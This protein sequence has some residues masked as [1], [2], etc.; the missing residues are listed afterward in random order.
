M[1]NAMT[2]G[3]G[4]A[5]PSA[6]R[7]GIHDRHLSATARL[8]GA[9][10]LVL[11]VC[12]G[13]ARGATFHVSPTGTDADN[14][15]AA[16]PW[17]TIQRCANQAQPGDTCRVH[18]GVYR[19]TVTPPRSGTAAA[20]IRFE[21]APGE[22]V[23]VSGADAF[24]GNWQPHSGS[25]WVTSTVARFVQLFSGGRMLNEARWPN[26]DPADLV[27][28]PFSR[29]GPGTDAS[30]LVAAAV[31]PGDW[32]GAMV[33]VLPG[34]GW[35]SE[36]RQVTTYDV[37]TRRMTFDNSF[38]SDPNLAPKQGD[39]YYL[40]GSLLALDS[41][42]EWFLDGPGSKLYL[43]PPGEIDPGTLALEI[44]QRSW[45]FDVT[46]LAY[47]E[48]A[49]F[50]IVASSIRIENSNFC[51][52]DGV[53]MEYVAHVRDHLGEYDT[54][55]GDAPRVIGNGNV[56]K[57]TVIA[58]S[59][60]M[61]LGIQGN[62][63]VIV[64]NVIHDIAY[65]G[66]M[67]GGIELYPWTSN[68]ARNMIAYNS[69]SRAGSRGIGLSGTKS[70]RILFNA[71]SDFT[72]LTND[73][74]GISAPATTLDADNTE[75]AY[76]EVASGI[77]VY[78]GGIYLDDGATNFVVHHNYVHDVA[79]WGI[80]FKAKNAVFNNTVLA[81]GQSPIYMNVSMPGNA[82]DASLS[83]AL[84]LN[85]LLD[86][87]T[88]LV[89]QLQ[90]PSVGDY[91]WFQSSVR[92]TDQWRRVI[93][94]FSTLSQPG[95]A[96]PVAFDLKAATTLVWQPVT[97]GDFDVQ[98]DNVTMEGASP[99]T[100]VD[101]ESGEL[102]TSLGTRLWT[103][104]GGG[105]TSTLSTSHPG[106]SCSRH[107]GSLKGTNAIQG[108]VNLGLPLSTVANG[109]YDLSG[110]SALSFDVRGRTRAWLASTSG[111]TPI[112][113]LNYACPVD[114]STAPTTT[115]AIDKAQ[116]VPPY[117][118]TFV[119]T[120]PDIGA[121]EAGSPRWAAGAQFSGGGGTC[122]PPADVQLNL[123]VS[124]A[125]PVAPSGNWALQSPT[126]WDDVCSFQFNVT[127]TGSGIG[128]VT[129]GGVNCTSPSPSG[130]ATTVT[131]GSTVTLTAMPGTGSTFA[132][133]S[134]A[135]IG[136][137]S[138]AITISGSASVT[139]RFEL[140]TAGN[141]NSGSSPAKSGC[142][143]AVGLDVYGLMVVAVV[144]ARRLIRRREGHPPTFY[145]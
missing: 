109:T 145:I 53:R 22:C 74:G 86:A 63:N 101:F 28:A 61:G 42:G 2:W 35:W 12:A 17:R 49:G 5:C 58:Q 48:I 79:W 113:G 1:S 37:A 33:F 71:V 19:E 97:Y 95:W 13:P 66:P 120:G 104:S 106:S 72:L 8:R 80:I 68:N 134:G 73:T 36:L 85:N 16:T 69:I 138:C 34:A 137:G 122:L 143:S 55:G 47:I 76:N 139:A 60:T 44:K 43:F 114:A 124:A 123:P 96:H 140:A 92:A 9:A 115:C 119:G 141:G 142:S 31:P 89:F 67:A 10:A 103:A 54:Y 14:G 20:H 38:P 25:I 56:W 127:L 102:T 136:T 116:P 105:S 81:A 3:S 23:T 62:D 131:D 117:T 87:G 75:I 57:N 26:A 125:Y 70:G 21:A 6:R 45:A 27:H 64:N 99:L 24:S 78:S 46:N 144:F 7:L 65:L 112:Q 90:L 11:L 132:G 15:T 118:S 4:W 18:A 30:G 98:V 135:C 82:W 126:T 128:T 129:G 108:Y 88:G 110:Y 111:P 100:L 93:I 83:S 77:G 84:V 39:R 51:T 29:A 32:T 52:V 121:F 59:S 91:G 130:C 94:P 133:W 41:P 40:Y 50:S 107:A